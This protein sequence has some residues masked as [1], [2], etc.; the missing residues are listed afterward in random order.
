M[1]YQS[2]GD[3]ERLAEGQQVITAVAL[4][5]HTFD[6]VEKVFLAKRATTK[7]FLPG[8]FELIGGH[9]DFGE[10]IIVGLTRE[11]LEEIGMHVEVGEPFACFTYVNE[12]KRSHSV[13]VAYFARFTDPIDRIALHPADHSEYVWVSIDELDQIYGNG[14]QADDAEFVV[15]KRGL[16]L[17]G[18]APLHV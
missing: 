3:S 6:G 10:D 12:I 13:E 17:L 9:I 16:E 1:S 11:V 18:G 4:I 5:H 14:K 7:K 8:V 15:V 2:I